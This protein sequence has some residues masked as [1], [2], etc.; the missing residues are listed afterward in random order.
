V[1][2]PAGTAPIGPVEQRP[3]APPAPA[4]PMAAVV[5]G[6]RLPL[7]ERYV[8]WLA[9]AGV[10][11]GVV[12][13]REVPRLWDRH[14]LNCVVLGDRIPSGAT[15]CDV[16]SGAGLPGIVLAI[17]RPDLRMVLLEPLAR[18]VAFLHEVIGDLGLDRAQVRRGRA[19]DLAGRLTVDVVTARAVAP[20][21]RLAAW[22][23]PLLYPGGTLLALKGRTAE[24][25]VR[26]AAAELRR[27]G[28]VD[29]VVE[30]AGE[31]VL[32]EP[33]WVV[34]IRV[35]ERPGSGRRERHRPR[36][37]VASRIASDIATT[38]RPR[39]DRTI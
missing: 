23:L 10:E 5:F 29:V 28:A 18:R 35:G 15:V 6:D 21:A 39:R 25:E 2:D 9:G 1:T 8:W 33:T 20:L 32:S 27:L 38:R 4:P 12:G 22:C 17:A 16:G 14:I 11:R 30:R 24:T 26:G 13:P 36:G 3:A 7:A 31:A 19:E 34:H 37:P